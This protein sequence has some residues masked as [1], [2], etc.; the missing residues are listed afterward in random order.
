MGHHGC[1]LRVEGVCLGLQIALEVSRKRGYFFLN[2]MQLEY[3]ITRLEVQLPEDIYRTILRQLE[4]WG[5][6][7]VCRS[8]PKPT[9]KAKPEREDGQQAS[10]SNES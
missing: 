4:M 5:I 8:L 3:L 2:R 7:T 9:A 10:G 6:D 1:G